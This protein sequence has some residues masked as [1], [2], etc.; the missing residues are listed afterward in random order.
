MKNK[1]TPMIEQYLSIKNQYKDVLLFYRMGDFYEL[2]FDDAVIASKALDITLTKRGRANGMDIPMC[3]VPFH[4]AD[5]YLPRLIKKGFNVA[6]CEQT[7]TPEQVKVSGKKGPLKREVVRI[8]SPG[9][10]TEDNLLESNINNFLGAIINLNNSI[11]ISWVDVSTGSFKSRNFDKK[12]N[13]INQ[14]QLL[15]NF[16]LRMNFSEL[17]ISEQM[18]LDFIAEE[19]HSIIKRQPSNIFHYSSSMRQICSYYSI[20]SLDGIGVFSDGEI[21]TAGVLLSYLNLTQCGKIPILSMIKSENENS[22]LEIDYFTQKSLEIVKNLSGK[23]EGSLISCID[24]T[25]TSSGARLLKQRIVEPF[26]DIKQ[27][28]EQYDL[29]DWFLKNR[30]CALQYKNNLKNIPDL[31]RSLSRISSLRGSPKDLVLISKGFLNI[32]E[33]YEDLTKFNKDLKKPNILNAISQNLEIDYSLFFNIQTAFKTDTSLLAKEGGFIKDGYNIK[34]DHLRKLRDNEFNEIIQLQKNYAEVSKVNSLKIKNNRVLGYHI[35]VRAMHDLSLRNTDQFIHRQT[36]AQTSRFTTIELNEIENQIQNSFYEATKIEMDIFNSFTK[37]IINIG[38]QILKIASSISELDISIMVASQA[39]DRNYIRPNIS[40]DKILEIIDGRHPVVE[41]QMIS[42]ENSFISNH[43]ILNESDYI[44]LI[45]GPNM[46]GKSTYLRQNALIVIMAQAGLYVPAKEA[47]IGI[48]DKIF[49]RV[50]ASDDLAKGQS[51]FMIEMI[52]TSAILNTSTERSLVILD[53]IGRGTATFDGLAIAWSVLDYLHNKIKPRTLFA[54]HYHELTSLKE[55]L[56]NLSCHKMAIKE[57]NDTIIFMHKINKGE[58]DK[59]YGIH[60]AQLA[61]LPTEV[62][63]RAKILLS[64][65]ENDSNEKK[66]DEWENI[67]QDLPLPN[68]NEIFF[69]EFDKIEADQISPREALDIIYKM[70]SL[71]QSNE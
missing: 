6:V 35:E 58:A 60:V 44:W 36:T 56:E 25:I 47:N 49:S 2:F 12:N 37:Q 67:L 20:V 28:N 65:L 50:G 61:G 38:S 43:C 24:D 53:E 31:E 15:N 29:I 26:Y 54:T 66:I 55:K 41:N 64:K 1:N 30:Q 10:I 13:Q 9:T 23:S 68:D 70:K 34:L 14:N 33:I 32:Y 69:K 3:G 63:Q 16:L 48:F 57:W 4:S 17:L 59:S 19:W 71:R 46:A 5:N 8:I 62:I 39:Q 42:S 11:S 22:F 7:E 40:D 27:I 21:I 52:E 51:T 45:T 18:K